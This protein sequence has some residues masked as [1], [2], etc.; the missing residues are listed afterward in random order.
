MVT[1]RKSFQTLILKKS[2]VTREK[3][4][5][6]VRCGRC[7]EAIR[8]LFLMRHSCRSPVVCHKG[9]RHLRAS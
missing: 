1:A 8:V 2:A 5:D 7:F 4:V 6:V 9:A 3:E